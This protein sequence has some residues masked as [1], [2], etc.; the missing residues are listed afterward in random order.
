MRR[1]PSTDNTERVNRLMDAFWSPL[2]Q[3]LPTEDFEGRRNALRDSLT[4]EL[5][6]GSISDDRLVQPGADSPEAALIAWAAAIN[7]RGVN[8]RQSLFNFLTV[9]LPAQ[10]HLPD[11]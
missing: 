4:T 11:I 1:N 2:R 9:S 8:V 10:P 7:G 3:L 5:L 6:S